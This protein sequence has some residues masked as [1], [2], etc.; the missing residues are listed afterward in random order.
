MS[1]FR[2]TCICPDAWCPLHAECPCGALLIIEDP[3]SLAFCP[4]CL[5]DR[6]PV[7]ACNRTRQS[8]IGR[9]PLEEQG[10]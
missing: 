4:E 2:E 6:L 8:E 1:S 10:E 3:D 5:M 9:L 7:G